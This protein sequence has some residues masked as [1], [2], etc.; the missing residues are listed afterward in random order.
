MDID[1]LLNEAHTRVENFTRIVLD[2]YQIISTEPQTQED[3]WG[4]IEHLADKKQSHYLLA[5]EIEREKIDE[6]MDKYKKYPYLK[7]SPIRN[8]IY[9]SHDEPWG[10]V[11]L[12]FNLF[13]KNY[14]HL[15]EGM[16]EKNLAE[17]LQGDFMME[18]LS[19][20]A[21]KFGKS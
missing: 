3:F 14:K 15:D 16:D 12:F 11:M 10:V 4:E 2:Y 8:S 6:L 1:K 7:Y 13:E 17:K 18:A 20:I 5:A 19:F 9:L 21:S